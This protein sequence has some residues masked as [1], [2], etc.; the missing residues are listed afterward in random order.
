MFQRHNHDTL[1]YP[2]SPN[3]VHL[4]E[5][6]LQININVFSFF[7]DEG[8]ARHLLIISRKFHQR[9]ANLLY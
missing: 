2:I 4:Y 6:L 3:D 8:C 7:D 1:P 9:V 5:D